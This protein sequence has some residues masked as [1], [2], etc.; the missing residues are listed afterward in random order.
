MKAHELRKVHDF[1]NKHQPSTR[2]VT[3]AMIKRYILDNELDPAMRVVI[4]EHHKAGRIFYCDCGIFARY[5]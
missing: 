4:E 1:L 2:T 5:R 3:K